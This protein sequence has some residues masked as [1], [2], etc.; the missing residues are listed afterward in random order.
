MLSFFE[1]SE[2]PIRRV[3]M[4]YTGVLNPLMQAFYYFLG[5]LVTHYE[6]YTGVT[7]SLLGGLMTGII[8]GYL[9]G[10]M[11][12]TEIIGDRQRIKVKYFLECTIQIA[13][14]GSIP[15]ASMFLDHISSAHFVHLMFTRMIGHLM[16]LTFKAFSMVL[17]ICQFPF[18]EEYGALFRSMG[19]GFDF[20]S[21]PTLQVLESDIDVVVIPAEN[22]ELII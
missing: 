6:L 17:L 7:L 11:S 14:L 3:G 9:G 16:L 10:Q 20:F 13:G 15:I 5:T 19:L 18:L 4:V 12:Q 2:Q 8:A 21:A 1:S 22:I